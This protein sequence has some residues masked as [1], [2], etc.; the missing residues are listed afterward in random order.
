MK[1]LIL[2]SEILNP[3]NTLGSTFELSQ[4]KILS[5]KFD[6]SILSVSSNLSL[7]SVSKSILKKL[8]SSKEN[9]HFKNSLKL[10]L[11]IFK[12]VIFKIRKVERYEI[13]GIRVYEG[14]NY[15]LFS[16]GN[17]NLQLVRWI[18]S[19]QHAFKE[20][21]L[22]NMIPDLIHAHGRFL[23]AGSLALSLKKK[24]GI[25]YIYTEHSTYYQNGIAPKQAKSKLYNVIFNSQIYITVSFSLKAEV[26]KYLNTIVKEPHIIPNVL[27]PLFESNMLFHRSNESKLRFINIASFD[28]KKG[29]DILLKSFAKAFS[30]NSFYHLTIVGDGPLKRELYLLSQELGLTDVVSFLG[31][32]SKEE[33]INLL[34]NSDI[35][36]FSSRIETFGVVVIEALSR[37][38][39]A[40][41]TKSGGPEHIVPDFCGI[42][43]DVEDIEGFSKALLKMADTFKSYDKNLIRQYALEN[44]GSKIFLSRMNY[45][46][47]LAMK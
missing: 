2:T 30:R 4:A 25:N 36:A 45:L 3:S 13:E 43:V 35:F 27:D 42:L 26:E 44:Y 37:G 47:N 11:E 28:S 46:Y 32:R 33:I 5:K 10:F 38:L 22:D 18:K 9:G 19:G 34:D 8:F 20:L 17:F 29:I 40:I 6:V 39:P 1:I 16:L 23:N 41:V 24:Y 15:T 7:T 14:K 21:L 31:V 12:H